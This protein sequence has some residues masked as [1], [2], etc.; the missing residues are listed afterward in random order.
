MSAYPAQARADLQRHFGL[1]IEH[2]GRDFSAFHAAEC[3]SCLPYD[4]ALL[5]AAIKASEPSEQS[6]RNGLGFETK[7]VPI[8]QFQDWYE[9]TEW[10]EVEDWQ[11]T[12]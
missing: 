2:M 4:S 9:N 1:N 7:S 6:G 8:D 12:R 11:V 5:R 10:K 3:L